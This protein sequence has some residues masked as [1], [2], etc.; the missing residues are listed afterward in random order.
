MKVTVHQKRKKAEI[1][2]RMKV[3]QSLKVNF[4]NKISLL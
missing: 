4:D 3:L 2:T 1:G